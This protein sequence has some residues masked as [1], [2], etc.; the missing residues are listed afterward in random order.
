MPDFK[1]RSFEPEMMD[2]PDVDAQLLHQNLRELETINILTGGPKLTFDAVKNLVTKTSKKEI[3]L[4]DIGYGAGDFLQ[5]MVRNSHKLPVRVRLIGVDYSPQVRSYIDTFHSDLP[6]HV[7]FVTA[8]YRDYFSQGH[9]VD[10]VTASLFCHHLNN[11]ELEEFLTYI[12]D[13]ANLGAVINDLHRHSVA[14]YGIKTL[15]RLFSSSVF[16]KNDAPLSVL[17]GF[18]KQEWLKILASARITEASLSW[19][20]AFRHLITIKNG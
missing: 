18:T 11:E 17:R 13:H 1:Q 14:Y 6:R 10:I 5:Y 2:A 19:R 15:T 20:W 8:D 16:T 12:N 4:V 9:Q 3:T 7:E